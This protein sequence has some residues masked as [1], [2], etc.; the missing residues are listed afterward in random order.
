MVLFLFCVVSL[1]LCVFSFYLGFLLFKY[2]SNNG[3]MYDLH[4]MDYQALRTTHIRQT[5]PT[6]TLTPTPTPT[7]TLGDEERKKDVPTW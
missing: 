2:F 5:T 6:P 7:P 1:L 4:G 3:S